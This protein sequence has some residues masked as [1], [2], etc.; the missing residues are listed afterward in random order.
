MNVCQ[1]INRYTEMAVSLSSNVS[2]Y[3]SIYAIKSKLDKTFINNLVSKYFMLKSLPTAATRVY[4]HARVNFKLSCT[5]CMFV[6][7]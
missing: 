6:C 7:S 2:T 1:S 3:T 4:L 5:I